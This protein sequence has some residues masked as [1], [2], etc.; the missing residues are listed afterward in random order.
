MIDTID[1]REP[2]NITEDSDLGRAVRIMWIDSGE[3]QDRGW[4]NRENFTDALVCSPC[5]T[6]GM[7]LGESA[8]AIIIAQ[9]RD[10][11]NDNWMAIQVIWKPSLVRKEWL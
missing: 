3:H 2:I 4:D 9:S 11:H 7:W 10:K 6:V 1:T 5:E 8:D